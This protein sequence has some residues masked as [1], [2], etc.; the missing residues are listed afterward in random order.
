MTHTLQC[1]DKGLPGPQCGCEASCRL[2]DE[3]ETTAHCSS[4][5]CIPKTEKE[6]PSVIEAPVRTYPKEPSHG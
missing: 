2:C 3:C 5:G 6:P 4:H 1:K